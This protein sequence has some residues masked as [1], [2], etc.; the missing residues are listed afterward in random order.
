MCVRTCDTSRKVGFSEIDSVDLT[1][2]QLT[3]RGVLQSVGLSQWVS[4]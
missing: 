2:G 1:S 4:K 3:L